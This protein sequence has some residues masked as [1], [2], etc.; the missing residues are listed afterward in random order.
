[1]KLNKK[2]ALYTAYVVLGIILIG[3]ATYYVPYF[4]LGM[5]LLLIAS[6]ILSIIFIIYCWFK[7]VLE[8][9]EE[10]KLWMEAHEKHN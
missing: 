8:S 1:M 10:H 9:R 2:A 5:I 6:S 7:A 3:L 4:G